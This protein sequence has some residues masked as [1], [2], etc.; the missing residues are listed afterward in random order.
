MKKNKIILL[1]NANCSTSRKA[2]D[3]L[4]SKKIEPEVRQYLKDPLT[5]AEISGLLHKLKISAFDLVRKK[6]KLYQEQ[7]KGKKL[8]EQQWIKL[9]H[10]HPVLIER[11]VV[12][13]GNKAVIGRPLENIE[14][15]VNKMDH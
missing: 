3:L 12:I 4:K 10:Q 5:E 13:A 6:D 1:H 15:L 7:Y 14:M 11:P 9:M 2:L 8:A